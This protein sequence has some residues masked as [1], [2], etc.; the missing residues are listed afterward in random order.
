M[1]DKLQSLLAI[2]ATVGASLPWWWILTSGLALLGS[3]GSATATMLTGWL[4]PVLLCASLL[5]LG[6][7]FYNLY[8]RGIRNRVTEVIAWLSLA[9]IV[10]FW[11]WHLTIGVWSSDG[12]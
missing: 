4:A 9:F 8:V 7:S 11:T 12:G 6:R 2:I 5:L 1:K 10:G 3:A